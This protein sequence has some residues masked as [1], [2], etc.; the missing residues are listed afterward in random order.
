M[1]FVDLERSRKRSFQRRQELALRFDMIG[2]PENAEE[3]LGMCPDFSGVT[4]ARRRRGNPSIFQSLAK[5][6][7]ELSAKSSCCCTNLLVG[8]HSAEQ[9]QLMSIERRPDRFAAGKV[10]P[11]VGNANVSQND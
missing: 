4:D 10:Y 5:D 7:H 11:D 1:W 3:R 2:H 8:M 6:I 9:R